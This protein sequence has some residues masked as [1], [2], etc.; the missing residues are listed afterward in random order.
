MYLSP[1]PIGMLGL[2]LLLSKGSKSSPSTSPAPRVPAGAAPRGE[3]PQEQA[4]KSPAW[5]QVMP[6]GLP[7][8]P[9]SGWEY[10][11]PPPVAVQKRAA[12][13]VSS[14]WAKGSGTF[15]TELVGGRWITFRAEKVRSG[16]QGVV[17]YRQRIAKAP[18]PA[19]TAQSPAAVPPLAVPVSTSARQY[20][21][22]KNGHTYRW[23]MRITGF[24]DVEVIANALRDLQATNI[25]VQQGPPMEAQFELRALA[26]K[27]VYLNES[28]GFP[29]GGVMRSAM[30]LEIVELVPEGILT[31]TAPAPA[32]APAPG[33][34]PLALRDL[35]MGDGLA[36]AAPLEEVKIVQKRLNLQPVDGR[37]GK[38]TRDAVIAFQVQTGLAPKG[39]KLEEL[40][41]RGFGAVK[42]ATWE[43][44]F[45]VRA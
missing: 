10:D 24:D 3:L 40:R 1:D 16:K 22:V 14:L 9:G 13:L 28:T 37:F 38:N 27:R 18:K 42:R 29:A 39:V 19:N 20:V 23:R 33:A 34:A 31:S 45:A 35:K 6:V 17:A 7:V 41:A 11:E 2:L 4:S 26:S 5:P 12:Q 15:K 8:F 21:D 36:P 30:F 44:L 25:R 32:A 43:Q